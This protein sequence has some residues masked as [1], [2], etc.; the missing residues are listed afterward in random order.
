[1]VAVPSAFV[2][3]RTV[4]PVPSVAPDVPS[5]YLPVRTQDPGLAIDTNPPV[6]SAAVQAPN[7]VTVSAAPA[8]PSA[9]ASVL[10]GQD[11]TP[12]VLYRFQWWDGTKWQKTV[13]LVWDGSTWQAIPVTIT[14]QVT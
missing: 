8:V 6:P 2:V 10:V 9:S 1:M 3:V 4:A 14:P 5:A 11:P 12:R 7:V 13:P